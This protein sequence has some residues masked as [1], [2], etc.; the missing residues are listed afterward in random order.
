MKIRLSILILLILG[1][2][3]SWWAFDSLY[4]DAWERPE[5]FEDYTGPR[6]LSVCHGIV[7]II[8]ILFPCGLWEFLD[9]IEI[10][11]PTKKKKD[12]SS[13]IFRDNY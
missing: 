4:Y 5:L 8:I 9:D 3:I 11:L 1:V 10:N 2:I 12:D 7:I 13:S 6:I